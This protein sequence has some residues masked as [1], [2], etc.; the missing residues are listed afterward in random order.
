MTKFLNNEIQG[1][2]EA[3]LE[4]LKS[5]FPRFAEA[6][7]EV[8]AKSNKW[9]VLMYGTTEEG[10]EWQVAYQN[11]FAPE[12]LIYHLFVFR[13]DG[14]MATHIP[15]QAVQMIPP[16]SEKTHG[17]DYFDW[18]EIQGALFLWLTKNNYKP[19]KID[20]EP[21]GKVVYQTQEKPEEAIAKMK[22][23]EPYTIVAI[24]A[25]IFVEKLKEWKKQQAEKA[26]TIITPEQVAAE[27]GQNA[28]II[29]P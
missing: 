20:M 3:P 21:A 2:Q 5:L 11:I 29:M 22:N 4:V 15:V 10:L 9:V 25:E 16:I 12:N 27:H 8:Q 19:F 17:V 7:E 23:G 18:I 24:K 28:K 1:E 26:S 13:L 14:V 6:S